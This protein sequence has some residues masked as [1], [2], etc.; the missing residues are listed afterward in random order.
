MRDA[1]DGVY[2]LLDVNPRIWGWYT[3][4]ARAGVDFTYL[5]WNMLRGQAV[6]AVSGCSGVRWVR[7]SA[8]LPIAISEILRGRLS[9]RAYI[10]SLRGPIESA[11]FA[12]D[13][14]FPGLL[15]VPLLAYSRAMRLLNG[16]PL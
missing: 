4:C 7:T 6:P 10:R 2:K 13:D 11:I 16:Q 9:P 15:E 3:L 12:A 5:L 8:D 1:R 14:P